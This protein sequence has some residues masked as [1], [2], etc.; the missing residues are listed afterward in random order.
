LDDLIIIMNKNQRAI[1]IF[2]KAADFETALKKLDASSFSFNKIFV[3][4]DNAE[5]ENIFVK[6]K[7]FQSL[8]D[9]FNLNIN[10][11]E[12]DETTI[13]LA[14]ALIH[15]D[16][17][18]DMANIYQEFVLQGQYLVMVEGEEADINIA[19]NIL[20]QSGIQQWVIYQI[21]TEH[22]EVI[23]VDRRRL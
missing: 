20:K 18:I 4:A 9:R 15:L 23:V 14:D 6:N 17:P 19:E 7:L 1:G 21:I 13:S 2:L 10:N 3:I 12:G 22:P 8:R 11:I 16:I 5:Q